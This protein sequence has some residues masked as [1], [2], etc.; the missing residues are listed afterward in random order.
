M[1]SPA[2]KKRVAEA[3][4]ADRV[5]DKHH[6]V[7]QGSARDRAIDARVKSKAMKGPR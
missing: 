7:V 6:G 1:A 3:M 4:A 5:W 2:Q